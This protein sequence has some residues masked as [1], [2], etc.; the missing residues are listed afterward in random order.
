M[1]IL[2]LISSSP[3]ADAFFLLTFIPYYDPSPPSWEVVANIFF[4][5]RQFL[6]YLEGCNPGAARSLLLGELILDY[7]PKGLPL[8][9][10]TVPR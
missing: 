10:V 5:F 1:T 6:N 7:T 2:Y 8:F 3:S 9:Q 4:S